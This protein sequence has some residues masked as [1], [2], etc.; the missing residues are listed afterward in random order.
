MRSPGSIG[1]PPATDEPARYSDWR[2]L[3]STSTTTPGTPSRPA[4]R[5]A[6]SSTAR[7]NRPPGVAVDAAVDPRGPE[8]AADAPAAGTP[9]ERTMADAAA[10][11]AADRAALARRAPTTIDCS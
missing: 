5:W 3:R 6:R 11:T 10:T 1:G 8:E 7:C 9:S 2:P 4:G